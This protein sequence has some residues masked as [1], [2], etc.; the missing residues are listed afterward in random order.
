MNG[1]TRQQKAE[2][3]CLGVKKAKIPNNVGH[4]P[5]GTQALSACLP[6]LDK[7]L[8]LEEALWATSVGLRT[9]SQMLP[10]K[11][12]Q[13]DWKDRLLFWVGRR[14]DSLNPVGK[15]CVYPLSV[16]VPT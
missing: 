9:T 13:S 15:Y 5:N 10:F 16:L 2:Q 11:L 3:K 8:S 6:H 4:H 1:K 7:P 12:T 14:S